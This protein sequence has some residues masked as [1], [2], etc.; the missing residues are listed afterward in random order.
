VVITGIPSSSEPDAILLV[1]L[2]QME[3]DCTARYLT[4]GLVRALHPAEAE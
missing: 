1:Y 2:S 3:E 4:E